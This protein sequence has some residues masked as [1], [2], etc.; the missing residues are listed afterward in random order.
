MIVNLITIAVVTGFQQEVRQKVSGFGSHIFIMGGGEQSIYESSPIL[1]KQKQIEYLR[2]IP[3]LKSVSRVAYKPVLFQSSPKEISFKLSNGDSVSEL[4]QNVLGATLKGI[5][6][7]YD[8]SFFDEYLKEGKLPNYKTGSSDQIL[9]SNYLAK[10]LHFQVGQIVDAFFVRN[11]PVKRKFKICGIYET[12]MEEFDSKIVISDLR[13]VQELNDWGIKASLRVEDT[14]YG[15]N[16]I[17]RADITGGNGN[18]RCDWGDGFEG[19]TGIPLCPMKDTVIRVVASDFFGNIHVPVAQTTIPDTTYIK[20]TSP[21]GL[22]T[23]TPELDKNGEVKREFLDDKGL[24]YAINFGGKKVVFESVIGQGSS[25]E[26]VGGFEINIKDWDQLD[27]ITEELKAELEFIPNEHNELLH[28]ISIKESQNEIFV[29]LSF[30]D[31]NVLIILILMI[32][33]GIIN[34]G[35]ALLVL[36]LVKT[37]QIG[38]LKGM[39]AKNWSIQKIFLYQAGFFIGRGMI[40]G[41]LIG[42]G[43]CFIQYKFNILSLNPAVYYLSKVPIQ[44][45]L[46][47]VLLLNIGTMAVCLL[48]LVIPSIV[49][50]RISPAR[51]IKFN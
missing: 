5:N 2:S 22:T 37:N 18:Y 48:A 34:M 20:I 36:I 30:L 51:A 13:Y 31:L 11:V 23:C 21:G 15:G 17:I 1:A 50:T 3:E 47:H 46:W 38:L 8:L 40:W 39:G 35:S 19:Y 27:L 14:L 16:L 28:V 32:L 9:I 44:I 49:I 41:N 7:D 6:A 24:K 45:N 25:D 12:G 26:Y 4:D 42:L 10:K 29:W 43:L 33:I